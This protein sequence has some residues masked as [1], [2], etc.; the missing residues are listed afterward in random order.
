MASTDLRF[1]SSST[2]NNKIGTWSCWVKRSG[3]G[4][5]QTLVQGAGDAS[6]NYV[7]R[8]TFTDADQLRIIFY[9]NATDGEYITTAKYRDTSA[10]YHVVMTID[11]TQATASNRVK[12]WINGEQVTSFGTETQ[13]TQNRTLQFNVN[14]CVYSVGSRYKSSTDHYLNGSMAHAHWIDGTAYDASAFGQTDSTTGEWVPKTSPSVTYGTNGFFLKF[15]N[16]GA[17][18]TDSSGN[19]NNFTVNGTMT[20]TIDTPT[21]NFCTLNPLIPHGGNLTFSNGNLS[22]ATSSSQ[23]QGALA[24]IAPNGG[25]YYFEAKYNTG[26]GIKLDIARADA[27]IRNMTVTNTSYLSYSSLGYGYQLNNTGYDYYCNNNSCTTWTTNRGNSTKIIMVALDIDN[28]KMWVGD[29]G[30]WYNK[31]GTANPETGADPLHDFSSDLNGE[32]WFINMSCEGSGTAHNLNFGGGFFGTTAVSSAGT[33][34]SGIGTFEY[35]VPS[36]Y[37]ALTS[38]GLNE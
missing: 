38:K 8:I 37:T 6:G 36:G 7:D 29:N 18:G 22:L 12:L 21:H 13:I 15:E 9:A 4:A 30:T 5:Y 25:K 35:D 17:F 10:W 11:T 16:S 20:Q 1:T 14:G 34:A 2:G 23:W 19:G 28:G 24:S 31:S 26:T 32:N 27:D 3:L 33:N